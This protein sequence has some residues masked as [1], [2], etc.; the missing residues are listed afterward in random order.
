[1]T[2][3][4]Q[5]GPASPIFTWKSLQNNVRALVKSPNLCC[6]IL[7][8][9]KVWFL[10]HNL[11]SLCFEKDTLPTGVLFS[12]MNC[13]G[14]TTADRLSAQCYGNV[15][16]HPME[17]RALRT[18]RPHSRPCFGLALTHSS[19]ST[20]AKTCSSSNSQREIRANLTHLFV[21][22]LTNLGIPSKT[23]LRFLL[24]PGSQRWALGRSG[25]W[26]S[27]TGLKCRV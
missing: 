3:L 26:S 5:G 6:F 22:L 10:L 7:F 15:A 16:G 9:E 19:L 13:T 17:V 8:R 14:D 21:P 2:P 20:Q 4:L 1:M 18:Y 23:G 27:E 24:R 12:Q 25:G 11:H